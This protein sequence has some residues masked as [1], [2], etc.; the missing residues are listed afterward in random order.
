[1]QNHGW[2]SCTRSRVPYPLHREPL[3]HMAT[4]LES[5]SCAPRIFGML[6]WEEHA[7]LEAT[8]FREPVSEPRAWRPGLTGKHSTG[9]GQA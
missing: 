6:V 5:K 4:V 2:C 9:I 7:L 3:R 1:M 8:G